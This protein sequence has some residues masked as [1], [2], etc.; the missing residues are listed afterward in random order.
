MTEAGQVQISRVNTATLRVPISGTAPLVMHKFSAKARQ[1][2]LD[3][4]QGRK[5]PKERRDPE[6]DYQAAFYK[7]ASEPDNPRYGFPA[8]AF[9]AATVGAARFYDKSVSMTSLRQVLFFRGIITDADEQQ[10]VEIFGTPKMREDVVRVGAGGSDLRF[11]PEFTQWSATLEVTYVQ[12]ALTQDSV[13]S[14]IDA[15]G[16]GVGIGEWRPERRGD[17]GTFAVDVS[18]DIEVLNG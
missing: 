5:A 18:R 17:F 3:T 1:Q 15:G 11:R 6:A 7:I 10:L 13:V 9:K 4:Q 2:M 12:S 8:V 16:L 14:L